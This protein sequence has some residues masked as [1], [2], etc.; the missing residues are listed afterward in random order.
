MWLR[1]RL[2]IWYQDAPR[3]ICIRGC[4]GKHTGIYNENY[5]KAE[6]KTSPVTNNEVI[7]WPKIKCENMLKE[8]FRAK[9][10]NRICVLNLCYIP[11]CLVLVGASGMRTE[12][13]YTVF[14]LEPFKV[15]KTQY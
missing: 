11:L 12:W 5:S 9:V 4:E 10:V 1:K 14:N 2:P 7:K 3:R 6:L 13:I 8:Q 15:V